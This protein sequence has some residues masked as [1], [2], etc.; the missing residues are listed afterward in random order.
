MFVCFP[1][2][3]FLLGGFA[4]LVYLFINLFINFWLDG[5]KLLASSFAHSD[6]LFA[7]ISKYRRERV[8]CG[9]IWDAELEENDEP[10]RKEK[11]KYRSLN[12][13]TPDDRRRDKIPERINKCLNVIFWSA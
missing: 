10:L 5:G 8:I 6:R 12:L 1:K 7:K 2:K 9:S 4:I 13:N 3:C 11:Q